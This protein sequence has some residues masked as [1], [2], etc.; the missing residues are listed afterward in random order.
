MPLTHVR[1]FRV[2][3]CE[4]DAYGHVN[5]TNYVRYMQETAFD[6]SAAAG[7]DFARYD[8][9]GQ[10]WLVRE[11]E[12]EYLKPL[13]Y[14]DTFEVKTWVV[15]FRRVRSRRAYEL[16]KVGLGELVAR[17]RTDWVYLDNA[18][19]RPTT[20]PAEMIAAF[21]PEGA[22][23]SAPPRAPFPAAPEPPPGVFELRRRVAWQDIDMAWHV[24]NAVYL[25]Y[26]EDC[27]MQLLSTYGWP[28]TRMSDE[29]FAILVRQHQIEY[30]QPAVMD[31]EL[32]VAT[33]VSNA[34]HASATRHYTIT[35]VGDGA[36]LARVHSLCVW[37]NL[38]TGQPTRIPEKFLADFASNIVA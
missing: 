21:F 16:R 24:N 11:T 2:R 14:G 38:S 6:A 36:L 32:E 19:N 35:R 23:Q 12:V 31:D 29:N 33:W 28:V 22:P 9:L 30:L 15:D 27:A 37:V 4:C 34:R 7:Y 3:Y 18:T 13:R 5:N 20:V 10:Y 1:Q 17:G 8:A 25:S 26:V